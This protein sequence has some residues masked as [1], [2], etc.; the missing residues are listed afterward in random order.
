MRKQNKIFLWPA[1]FDST[2][3]RTQGRKTPKNVAVPAPRQDEL[4]KA[5]Q[6]IGLQTET[7]AEAKHPKNPWQKTGLIIVNKHTPK[8]QIIRKVSKELSGMRAQNRN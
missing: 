3:T 6:K 8:T 5:A 7:F 1:Y 4:Q 2:K